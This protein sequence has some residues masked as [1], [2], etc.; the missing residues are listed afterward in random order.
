MSRSIVTKVAC[1][2]WDSPPGVPRA[3]HYQWA[4]DDYGYGEIVG[5]TQY[6]PDWRSAIDSAYSILE[7]FRRVE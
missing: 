6:F 7:R 4:E 3:M 1:I 2:N 5:E